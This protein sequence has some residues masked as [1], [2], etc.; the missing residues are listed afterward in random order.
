MID[1]RLIQEITRQVL[2]QLGPQ[3][4]P[5]PATQPDIRQGFIP[6]GVSVRH[7]H[8]SQEDLNVLY[9]PGAEL[10]PLRP[11]VQPGEYA[12]EEVVTLV[13]PKMRCLGPVRVLG[14]IRKR[15]QVEVSLTDAYLLGVVPPVRASGNLEGAESIII[16]GPRGV[17]HKK[18]TLIRAN[19]HIHMNSEHAGLLGLKDNQEVKVRVHADRPMLLEGVQLRVSEKFVTE[20]HLDTDDA[21]ASGLTQGDLVQVVRG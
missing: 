17:L 16:V 20:M 10:H 3:S 21:N 13:G 4:S 1:E 18:E 19:R 7:L 12:A 9:G 14:P 15:T 5:A 8:L 2:E 11:L 6:V